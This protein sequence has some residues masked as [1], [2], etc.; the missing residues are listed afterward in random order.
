[1][2]E[3]QPKNR[4]TPRPVFVSDFAPHGLGELPTESEPQTR[5]PLARGR[6]Q[7]DERLEELRSIRNRHPGTSIANL[8]SDAPHDTATNG[9]EEFLVL[10]GLRA[11]EP[12]TVTAEW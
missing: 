7:L 5:T 8:E 2:W 12:A 4:A 6:I 1:M 11:G 3:S 10:R 9:G